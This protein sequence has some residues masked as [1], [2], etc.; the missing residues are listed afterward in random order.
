MNLYDERVAIRYGL[1]KLCATLNLIVC[2]QQLCEILS[3]IVNEN[4]PANKVMQSARYNLCM[5]H[6]L[7]CDDCLLS[8]CY[9][10]LLHCDEEHIFFEEYEYFFS[11]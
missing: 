1:G 9:F 11:C 8:D 6:I 3:I 10:T 7:Y 2:Y 4:V 5:E